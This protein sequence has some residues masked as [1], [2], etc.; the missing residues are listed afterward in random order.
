MPARP[1]A[2]RTSRLPAAIHALVYSFGFLIFRPSPAA[3]LAILV[4]HFLIDRY[5]LARYLVWLKNWMGP[6]GSN[7]AWIYCG[8]TG[9]RPDR[10]DWLVVW[11]LIIVDNVVHLLC[12][13]LALKYL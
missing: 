11:L 7:W 6:P 1:V 13:G 3:W 5:R 8:A 10:P 9:Y 4:S 2:N 12:N